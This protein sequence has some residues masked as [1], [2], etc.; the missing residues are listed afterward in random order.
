MQHQLSYCTL[1]IYGDAAI[2]HKFVATAGR[3]YKTVGSPCV[4]LSQ[5]WPQQQTS[6]QAGVIDRLLHGA[7]QRRAAAARR[8]AAT[9]TLSDYLVADH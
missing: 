2:T 3:V 8:Y 9:A 6:L 1:H 7:Q 5:H 4:C